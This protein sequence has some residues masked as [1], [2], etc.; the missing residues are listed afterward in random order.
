L[1]DFRRDQGWISVSFVT[2]CS[3]LVLKCV[4][5]AAIISLPSLVCVTKSICNR[6]A[7][8]EAF[9]KSGKSAKFAGKWTVMNTKYEI[10][11]YWSEADGCFLAEVLNCEAHHR[12]RDALSEALQNAEGMIDA[13]CPRRVKRLVNS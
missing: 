11:V 1:R 10:V 9:I 3:G 7:G 6:A 4:L 2:C 13:T 5:L 8:C 12:R